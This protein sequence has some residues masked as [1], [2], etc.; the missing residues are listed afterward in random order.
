MMTLTNLKKQYG[1]GDDA[2]TVLRDVSLTINEGEFVAIMGQSGSGKST[3]LNIIG[4][5]DRE[6]DGWYNF[7][8][9]DTTELSRIGFTTFRNQKIGWVFQNFKLI[10]NM[11]VAD[12]VG[13]PLIYA[14]ASRVEIQNRIHDVLAQVGL[15]GHEDKLPGQLSGGQQQRVAIARALIGQPKLLLAD[16]PTG[17]LD[18]QTSL[19]I[20][21]LFDDLHAQGTTIIMVTHDASVGQRA[22]RIIHFRDGQIVEVADAN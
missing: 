19:E 16:E 21:A 1:A 14:G 22:E 2:T 17:A 6:Y 20:L 8:G 9:V 5:L 12:N 10:D 4:F 13:L 3:L 18:S 11:S 15:A 7:D